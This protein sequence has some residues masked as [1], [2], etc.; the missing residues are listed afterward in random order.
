MVALVLGKDR[1]EVQFLV[2]APYKLYGPVA[3]LAEAA[4]SKPAQYEFE[5]RQDYH[6]RIRK[7][8]SG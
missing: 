6:A 8:Q 3:Q 2:R 5:S 1:V 7:W 4:D